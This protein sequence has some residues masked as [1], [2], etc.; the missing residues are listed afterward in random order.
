MESLRYGIGLPAKMAP[1][2]GRGNLIV[3]YPIGTDPDAMEVADRFLFGP[4]HQLWIQPAHGGQVQPA[5]KRV[6]VDRGR[7]ATD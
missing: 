7:R 1:D 4:G 2:T 6:D 3:Q 5:E